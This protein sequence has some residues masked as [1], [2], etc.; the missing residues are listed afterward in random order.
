MHVQVCVWLGSLLIALVPQQ[1][2]AG[3]QQGS[4]QHLCW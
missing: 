4:K 1:A 3:A 2:A